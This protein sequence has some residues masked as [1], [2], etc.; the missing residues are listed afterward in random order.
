MDETGTGTG[1]AKWR[2]AARVLLGRMNGGCE[3]GG[4]AVAV[5]HGRRADSRL[6]AYNCKI[7]VL[8]NCGRAG[9]TV[10]HPMRSPVH[11][12]DRGL[13]SASEADGCRNFRLLFRF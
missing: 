4:T 3:A 11:R 13:Q 10:R 1:F 2:A 5:L 9:G 12:G 8:H 6:Q 7:P